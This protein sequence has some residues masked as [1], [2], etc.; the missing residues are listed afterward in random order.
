MEIDVSCE[1][2][3]YFLD[4]VERAASR[5][6][7]ATGISMPEETKLRSGQIL[8]RMGHST[9]SYSQGAGSPWWISDATFDYLRAKAQEVW[10]EMAA[11]RAF[12]RI[13]RQKL[14][15][16]PMF[17]PSDVVL[18][19][20]VKSRLRAWTGRG[21]LILDTKSAGDT[22]SYLGGFEIAQLCIPGLMIETAPDSRKWVRSPAFDRMLEVGPPLPAASYFG[23][24]QA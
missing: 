11:D 2:D 23:S 20:V 22:I 21:R 18:R 10:P 24:R 12:R 3:H 6:F 8:Y 17:G 1:N 4:P 13:F 9:R 19:A 15:V 5:R 7:A 16:A 14:A